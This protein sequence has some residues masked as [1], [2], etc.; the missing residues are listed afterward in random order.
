MRRILAA[1][2]AT[3]FVLALSASAVAAGGPPSLSF[4]VDG[5]R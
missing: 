5:Q 2:A 4:Y 3:T 1:I